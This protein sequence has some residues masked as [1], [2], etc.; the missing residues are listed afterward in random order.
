M[1]RNRGRKIGRKRVRYSRRKVPSNKTLNEKIKRIQNDEEVKQRISSRSNINIRDNV[2]D[3]N[4][5]FN[6]ILLNDSV[7]QGV[8]V[9]ARIGDIVR[10]T[11]CKMR[12]RLTTSG[13]QIGS[14]LVRAMVIWD[15]QPN[16]HILGDVASTTVGILGQPSGPLW[17]NDANSYVFAPYNPYTCGGKGTRYKVL[18]DKV[19][20]LTPKVIQDVNGEVVTTSV[21]P[22]KAFKKVNIKLNNKT[23]YTR[24]EA[25]GL[26]SNMMTGALYLVLISDVTANFPTGYVQWK[27]SYKDE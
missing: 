14:S 13:A 15:R 10:W 9:A 3:T 22:V 26:I 5:N 2:V 1:V 12:M 8:S 20:N 16:E 21:V 7:D 6:L 25:T 17:E 4:T 23:K 19:I 27:I 11:S 24:G 18:Y